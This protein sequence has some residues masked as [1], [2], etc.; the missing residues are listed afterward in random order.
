[1]PSRPSP[2][3]P[4]NEPVR[5]MVDGKERVFDIDDPKLPDWVE[6]NKLTA[7]DYPYDDRM[8]SKEYEETLE[9][10][11]IELVKLQS[12]MQ[13]GGQRVLAVFE[14]ATRPARAAPSSCCAST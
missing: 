7:A 10:L 1:M 14:A 11:Q 6:E 13:A 12:W 9:R 3:M 5:I 2:E 4:R 8:N